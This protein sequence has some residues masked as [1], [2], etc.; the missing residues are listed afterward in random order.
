MKSL[1][2]YKTFI[3]I[4]TYAA[5]IICRAYN[6]AAPLLEMIPENLVTQMDTM[7]WL[8]IAFFLKSGMNRAENRTVPRQ[9]FPLKLSQ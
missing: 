5:F 8:A 1:D 4:L 7:F 9:T 2:Q 6:I 3:T